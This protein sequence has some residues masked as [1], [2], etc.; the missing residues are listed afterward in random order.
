MNARIQHVENFRND[1]FNTTSLTTSLLVRSNKFDWTMINNTLLLAFQ[2]LTT[3]HGGDLQYLI[4]AQQY[5][6]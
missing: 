1:K 4:I 5:F 3:K 6:N 2:M